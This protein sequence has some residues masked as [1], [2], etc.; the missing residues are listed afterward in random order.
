MKSQ[1]ITQNINYPTMGR[2]GERMTSDELKAQLLKQKE[3]ELYDDMV[4]EYLRVKKLIAESG[5]L[6][7]D[8]CCEI[9]LRICDGK[10]VFTSVCMR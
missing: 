9:A 7:H 6:T 2:K 4:K 10:G 8:E 1:H 5:A 3:I